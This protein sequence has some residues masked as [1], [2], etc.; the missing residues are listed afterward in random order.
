MSFL[1]SVEKV[2][3]RT[4]KA[5]P[6]LF[7]PSLSL[8]RISVPTIAPLCPVPTRTMPPES[9]APEILSHLPSLLENVDFLFFPLAKFCG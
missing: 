7:P 5:P 1:V 8:T 2:D 6:S 9:R 4:G 3:C